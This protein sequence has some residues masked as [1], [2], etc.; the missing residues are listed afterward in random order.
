MSSLIIVGFERRTNEAI[1]QT[2]L[3]QKIIFAISRNEEE[4]LCQ[5]LKTDF[6]FFNESKYREQ[7]EEMFELLA[8][9][10]PNLN[11]DQN[12]TAWLKEYWIVDCLFEALT[13][14]YPQL[15]SAEIVFYQE[16]WLDSIYTGR[17]SHS[18]LYP[19]HG[20]YG[21]SLIFCK[22]CKLETLPFK[23]VVTLPDIPL[24]KTPNYCPECY[25]HNKTLYYIDLNGNTCAFQQLLKIHKL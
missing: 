6:G 20:T 22:D 24:P 23:T 11:L 2:A 8:E 25:E 16:R 19:E 17:K 5:W 1:S 13:R 12:K 10:I 3:I 21:H 4:E 15:S 14:C 18:L 9:T 7:I